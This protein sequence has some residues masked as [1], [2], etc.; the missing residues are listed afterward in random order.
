MIQ[1]SIIPQA[2]VDKYSIKEKA[3][4]GYIFSQVTKR[5]Y[6]IP[7]VGQIYNDALVQHLENYE[8]LPSRKTPVL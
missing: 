6:G 3:H 8:Y 4:N 5:M 7:Q 2:F 1:I